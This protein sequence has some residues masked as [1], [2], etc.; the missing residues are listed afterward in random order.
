MLLQKRR[1]SGRFPQADPFRTWQAQIDPHVAVTIYVLYHAFQFDLAGYRRVT[2]ILPN[3]VLLLLV[4]GISAGSIRKLI[5][6]RHP[7]Y[8]GSKLH[9][10]NGLGCGIA[11]EPLTNET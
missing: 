7:T 10:P 1:R 11:F 5:K 4:P 2:E 9:K 3:V 6:K 8:T